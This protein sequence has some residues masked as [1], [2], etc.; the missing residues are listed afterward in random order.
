MGGKYQAKAPVWLSEV[1]LLSFRMALS[2]WW[3][4]QDCL[5]PLHHDHQLSGVTHRAAIKQIS[6]LPSASCRTGQA[7]N[8]QKG[9]LSKSSK[10]NTILQ[11]LRSEGGNGV[12]LRNAGF[13]KI[14]KLV[15]LVHQFKL[16][17]TSLKFCAMP[18]SIHMVVSPL[19]QTTNSNTFDKLE[20]SP[21]QPFRKAYP[22]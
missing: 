15:K 2:S 19:L 5:W 12:L 9:S 16:K 13:N 3:M 10:A 22:T 6:S 8:P 7:Q 1:P 14:T 11:S 20:S 4:T 21:V 18:Q 17:R